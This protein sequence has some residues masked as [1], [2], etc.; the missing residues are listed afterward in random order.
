MVDQINEDYYALVILFHMR[1]NWI[2]KVA[3]T[4]TRHVPQARLR[5]HH[6]ANKMPSKFNDSEH[7]RHNLSL[8]TWIYGLKL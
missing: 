6:L 7:L 8:N 1:E 3:Y 2:E 4:V 5:P